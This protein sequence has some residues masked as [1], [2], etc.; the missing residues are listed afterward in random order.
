M[1]YVQ[2][3][4]C[5]VLRICVSSWNNRTCSSR[6]EKS[7]KIIKE[8]FSKMVYNQVVVL[9][10]ILNRLIECLHSRA[11]KLTF[12]P[13]QSQFECPFAYPTGV[14]TIQADKPLRQ[15]PRIAVCHTQCVML[16]LK[17]QNKKDGN[18]DDKATVLICTMPIISPV[19]FNKLN[20]ILNSLDSEWNSIISFSLF[21]SI[22]GSSVVTPFDENELAQLL[23]DVSGEIRDQHT[24]PNGQYNA[25]NV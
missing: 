12:E 2:R 25:G 4:T 1:K 9:S 15:Y 19:L 23:F 24:K 22:I 18:K 7:H 5:L 14:D 3:L 17:W 8:F 16:P 10:E 13:M 20:L 11:C 21:F 6:S